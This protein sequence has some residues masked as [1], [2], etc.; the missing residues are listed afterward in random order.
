MPGIPGSLAALAASYWSGA[1][2]ER[3]ADPDAAAD[4]HA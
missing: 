1:R 3:A 2:A 4:P